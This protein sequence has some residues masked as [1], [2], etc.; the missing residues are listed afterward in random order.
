MSADYMNLEQLIEE[1]T[2]LKNTGKFEED[3]PV[4]FADSSGYNYFVKSVVLQDGD[5][6]IN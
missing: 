5:V 4:F 3:L 2:R 6:V 1:L